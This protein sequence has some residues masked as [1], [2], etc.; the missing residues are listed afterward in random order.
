M[1]TAE[2]MATGSP[3]LP[4]RSRSSPWRHHLPRPLRQDAAAAPGPARRPPGP[5]SLAAGG[6]GGERPPAPRGAAVPAA[7]GRRPPPTAQRSAR[8]RP[9]RRGARWRRHGGKRSRY[10]ASAAL[11]SGAPAPRGPDSSP[12]R[13]A[14]ELRGAG[15]DRSWEAGP[16]H[17]SESARRPAGTGSA[18]S[19][20]R[21]G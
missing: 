8:C 5:L 19:S 6:R 15:P 3:A 20:P 9:A 12:Q 10:G 7:K 16:G 2:P 1:A 4:W 18:A 17:P 11:P 13:P 21:P 14:P